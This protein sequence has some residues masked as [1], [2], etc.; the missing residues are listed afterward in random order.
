MKIYLDN[1][2]LNRPFDD[3]SNLRVRLES[4]AVNHGH[5]DYVQDRQEWQKE[6]SVDNALKAMQ[7]AR[8]D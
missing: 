2:C 4:E 3:Q 6:Y 7:S 8:K 5:G 1:C